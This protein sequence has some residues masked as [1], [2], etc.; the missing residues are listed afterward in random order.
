[1]CKMKKQTMRNLLTIALVSTMSSATYAASLDDVVNAINNGVASITTV[2]TTNFAYIKDKIDK[3][4]EAEQPFF[5]QTQMTNNLLP[6]TADLQRKATES[7]SLKAITDRIGPVTRNSEIMTEIA[8][9]PGGDSFNPFALIGFLPQQAQDAFQQRLMCNNN[10]FNFESLIAPSTYASK[11]IPGCGDNPID[12]GMYAR[13][14]I[15]NV[16]YQAN[17]INDFTAKQALDNKLLDTPQQ[18]ASL[19]SSDVYRDFSTARRYLV[20]MRSMGL[21]TLYSLYNQRVAIPDPRTGQPFSQM[22]LSD[23]IANS[24]VGNPDWY[25]EM[26]KA[27]PAKLAREQV[28]IL[29]ELQHELHQLRVEQQRTMALLA[30]QLLN[31]ANTNATFLNMK[32]EPIKA[33]IDE[34]KQAAQEGEDQKELDDEAKEKY[35]EDEQTR[36][37]VNDAKSYLD[38]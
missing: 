36:D 19:A 32:Q 35:I 29:A 17:P 37:A 14:F 26:L 27:Y 22:G 15:E 3:N 24:R 13:N 23:Q 12:Q 28:F 38:E 30:V 11:I 34:L 8:N 7:Q 33:K 6:I 9:M 31:A 2:M 21:S 25:D 18:A 16:A 20:S 10:N 5:E 4:L 1:M